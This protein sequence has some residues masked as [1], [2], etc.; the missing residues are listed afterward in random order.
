MNQRA[1][2]HVT[3]CERARGH[4]AVRERAKSH[5]TVGEQGVPGQQ[6]EKATSQ[7]VSEWS[8]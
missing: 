3:A 2:G 8:H 4:V 6:T 5:V 1:H 7:R